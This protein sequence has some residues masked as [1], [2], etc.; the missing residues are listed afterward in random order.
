MAG[1]PVFARCNNGEEAPRSPGLT[2]FQ[3]T[4]DR[5]L[6]R[7]FSTDYP[8]SHAVERCPSSQITQLSLAGVAVARP[9][10]GY[11]DPLWRRRCPT[12]L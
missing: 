6:S 10:Y 8:R 4:L 9:A 11:G 12:P 5:C 3:L 7:R 2:I 1:F